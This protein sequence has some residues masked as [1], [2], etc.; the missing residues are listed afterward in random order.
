[1]AVIVKDET[2]LWQVVRAGVC[3]SAWEFPGL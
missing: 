1:V 3:C 2:L